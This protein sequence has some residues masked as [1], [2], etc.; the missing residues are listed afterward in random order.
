[1][2]LDK[3]HPLGMFSGYYKN[4][5]KYRTGEKVSKT[6][7][8]VSKEKTVKKTVSKIKGAKTTKKAVKNKITFF[9]MPPF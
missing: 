2:Q 4:P 9:I 6:V 5:E 1:M 8:T 7:K 3:G